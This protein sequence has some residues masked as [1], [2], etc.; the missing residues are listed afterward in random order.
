M[1]TVADGAL[2]ALAPDPGH[3]IGQALC[4]K[5]KAA[6]ELVGH[7]DRLLYPLRRTNPTNAGDP[8]WQRISWDEA[9]DSIAARL[10]ELAGD[11]GPESAVF[12]SAS[13]STSAMS[14]SVDC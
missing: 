11:H 12:G 10:T 8:G 4:I 9:L 1:A 5:G 2:V 7:R 6:P 3:P 13:P 14:D